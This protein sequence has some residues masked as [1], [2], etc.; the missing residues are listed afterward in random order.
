[1]LSR[2]LRFEVL[3]RDRFTCQ[4]CGKKSPDVTLQIDH[5]TPVSKGGTDDII[6]L[7]TSCPD[8]NQGKTNV[9]LDDN[10]ALGRQ[11]EHLEN[12][13][14]RREQIEMMFEW[15]KSLDVLKDHSTDLFVDYIKDI[16]SPYEPTEKQIKDIQ[17]LAKKYQ[18]DEIFAAIDKSKNVY[19]KYDENYNFT[20]ESINIFISKIGGILF[21]ST[22]SPVEN[23]MYYI[24]GVCKNKFG[25]WD[26]KRGFLILKT[27]IKALIENGVNE[28]TII[29]YLGVDVFDLTKSVE[30]FSEWISCMEQ[31]TDDI[32]LTKISLDLNIIEEKAAA[33]LAEIKNMFEF[34]TYINPACDYNSYIKEIDRYLTDQLNN[35]N[36][37]NYDIFCLKAL[38]ISDEKI[39]FFLHDILQWYLHKWIE[40]LSFPEIGIFNNKDALIFKTL[41][42]NQY[43]SDRQI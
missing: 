32:K 23:K 29:N 9:L 6:N 35:V 41:L 2:K 14:E 16:V 36:Y 10:S 42:A 11:R 39:N 21:N 37:E 27:Y 22:K 12:L 13:Q 3:K 43:F 30:S 40:N 26:D 7:V 8:C 25:D 31:W 34:I 18:M 4:Y 20:Q 1:M 17:I 15:K 19:L 5:V 33:A 38:T 24:R 28:E